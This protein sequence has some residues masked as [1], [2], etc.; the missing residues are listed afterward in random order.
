MFRGINVH[1]IILAVK[2][3]HIVKGRVLSAVHMILSVFENTHALLCAPGRP[4]YNEVV[5]AL[6]FRHALTGDSHG[7][8]V[9][10]KL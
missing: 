3:H 6:P 4:G 9:T 10:V 7:L 5:L 8:G 1:A 2:K